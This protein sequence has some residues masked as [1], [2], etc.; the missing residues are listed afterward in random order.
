[1]KMLR[2]ALL[3]LVVCMLAAAP[4]AAAPHVSTVAA[5]MPEGVT[6]SSMAIGPE[7]TAYVQG[8]SIP[9]HNVANFWEYN[10]AEVAANGDG[11]A[12]R[13]V[14]GKLYRFHV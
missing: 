7:G 8:G 12:L 5:H 13:S 14:P 4:A 3:A 9:I 10:A 1:M 6:P 11:W 2:A